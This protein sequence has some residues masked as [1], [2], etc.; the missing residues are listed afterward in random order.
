[1]TVSSGHRLSF[2]EEATVAVSGLVLDHKRW[3]LPTGIIVLVCI[4]EELNEFARHE[5]NDFAWYG[6]RRPQCSV[7]ASYRRRI[8][9]LLQ[10]QFP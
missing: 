3:T 10:R 7:N 1:V 6:S 4:G 2:P 5:V 9:R 8:Y